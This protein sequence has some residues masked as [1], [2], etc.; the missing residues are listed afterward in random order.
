MQARSDNRFIYAT[1]IDLGYDPENPL[2]LLE[3]GMDKPVD[4]DAVDTDGNVICR[5]LDFVLT[6]DRVRIGDEPIGIHCVYDRV[7]KI[8]DPERWGHVYVLA[9][10]PTRDAE[11]RDC[12]RIALDMLVSESRNLRGRS[13]IEDVGEVRIA[14][15]HA[16]DRVMK[17]ANGA[18]MPEPVATEPE[19]VATDDEVAKMCAAFD[20]FCDELATASPADS[21]ACIPLDERDLEEFDLD[22]ASVEPIA[23]FA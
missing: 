18:H 4:W 15:R 14:W 2:I 16:P 13:W 22:Q 12:D 23:A 9:L 8:H 10:R 7:V 3:L 20:A 19:P 5:R 11:G 17:L 21:S 1:L 6:V